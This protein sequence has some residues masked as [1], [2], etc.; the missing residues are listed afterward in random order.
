MRD[1]SLEGALSDSSLGLEVKFWDAVSGGLE[2]TA[3]NVR[4][5]EIKSSTVKLLEGK[6]YQIDLV[7]NNAMGGTST[8]GLKLVLPSH[9]ADG[10][11]FTTILSLTGDV[12]NDNQVD[13]L[14]LVKVASQ[15]GQA[16]ENLSGDVNNDNQVDILDLVKVAGNF[17]KSN[18][19]AAPTR[20]ANQ[21]TFTTQQKHSIQSAIVE[22]ERMP[23]RSET[24]ELVFNLLVSILPEKLPAR[25]QLLP[26]Y[27]NPFNP[28]TWIPFELSQDSGVKLMIYD[29]SGNLVRG[30]TVG[31]L[32]AGSY[33]GQSR[34]IYWDGKT[35]SGE[36]VASGTYF[37]TLTAQDYTSTQ[38]MIILK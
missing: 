5:L 33:V 38:K 20:L 13:I 32:Q 19:V 17:G 12:N 11:V 22:L 25:T 10:F 7:T 15:F 3:N 34:A 6:Q 31:Y 30:I 35:D 37:Y 4:R 28:E 9:L 8:D 14:D 21:L 27:P 26:N 1:I 29:V 36:S 16:G 18:V 24:E 23:V 2:T